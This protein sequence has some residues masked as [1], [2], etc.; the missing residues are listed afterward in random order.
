M[1]PEQT[2]VVPPTHDEPPHGCSNA[3]PAAPAPAG[4]AASVQT[5]TSAAAPAP[6]FMTPTPRRCYSG[7]GRR[8]P[9]P[10]SYRLI[11]RTL[12]TSITTPST[13]TTA[14]PLAIVA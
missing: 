10:Q 4:S 14:K 5:R 13:S 7:Q 3:G 2:L 11:D 12:S 1:T 6:R 8:T 9:P